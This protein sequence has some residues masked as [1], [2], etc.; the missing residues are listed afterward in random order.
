[1]N[2]LGFNKATET[3]VALKWVLNGHFQKQESR[4]WAETGTRKSF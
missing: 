1:M 3:V 2:Y 4:P